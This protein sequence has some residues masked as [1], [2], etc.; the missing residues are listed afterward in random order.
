MGVKEAADKSEFAYQKMAARTDERGWENVQRLPIGQTIKVNHFAYGSFEFQVIATD[1]EN[2]F[3]KLA[4][5]VNHEIVTCR[6]YA[7][8]STM[9]EAVWFG[10]AWPQMEGL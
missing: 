9:T 7:D 6:T 2:G 5:I 4:E 1:Q 10:D 3:V 8:Y